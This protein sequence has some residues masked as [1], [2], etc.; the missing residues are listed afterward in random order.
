MH[1]PAN[2]LARLALPRLRFRWP[3]HFWLAGVVLVLAG[4]PLARAASFA[5]DRAA[6]RVEKLICQ[7]PEVS[8]LDDY[9]GR[10]HAAARSEFQHAQACL[11][12]DQ[13]AWLRTVRDACSDAACLKRVYLDRLAVLQAVQPGATSLRVLE[14]PRVP[15]LVWIVA[16]AADQEAAPRNR[17]TRARVERGRILDEVT[18]GDGFVLQVSGGRKI[19]IQSSMLL[20][21]ATAQ[22]L[23]ALARQPGAEFEVRGQVDVQD[24][25]AAAFAAGQ[26]AF[27]YRTA[28]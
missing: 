4:M 11:L 6:T 2:G 22:G 5:C 8:D 19:V 17:P 21:P 7:S 9:L 12:G 16:P 18:V 14:L 1:M 15:P 23:A 28:P 24:K 27:V 25:A 3:L 26:C 13:R 20:E 10:Y